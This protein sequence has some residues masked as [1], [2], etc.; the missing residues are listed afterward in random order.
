MILHQ[1]DYKQIKN[2]DELTLAIGN[3]DGVHLGH[4]SIIKK[5]LSYKDTKHGLLTFDPH[6]QQLFQK[7]FKLLSRIDDK[8]RF[9]S[10]QNIEHLFV[11]KFTK[12]FSSLSSDEFINFLKRINVKRLVVGADFGFGRNKSGT[13][14][15]LRLHFEVFVLDEINSSNTRISSSLI[16]ELISNAKFREAE[17]MLG[18]PFFIKG[19]IVSGSQVGRKLSFPT[20]NLDYQNYIIPKTGVYY[21]KV[22]YNKK[23]Y[24]GACSI[25]YNLTLNT[26]K[27]IRFE[28]F[29]LDQNI[30]LYNEEITVYFIEYLRDEI[31]FANKEA[32]INQIKKDVDLIRS[33]NKK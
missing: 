12:E 30:D 27:D 21:V 29:L 24:E 8:I 16:K 18:H 1:N 7:D 9:L 10:N 22:K 4:I 25:G 6:P 19:K 28:I 26:Q 5:L 13:I 2:D 14:N 17:E 31:K 11:V 33:F 3:F 32:L 15:D 20:A 23:V